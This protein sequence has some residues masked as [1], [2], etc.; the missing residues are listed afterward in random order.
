[1]RQSPK[2][3]PV[4]PDLQEAGQ[5]DGISELRHKAVYGRSPFMRLRDNGCR[6]EPSA[7]A[8]GSLA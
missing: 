5:P 2:E 3:P 6:K 7:Y 1:M 8:E 4:Q